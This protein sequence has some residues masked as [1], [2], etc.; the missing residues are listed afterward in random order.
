MFILCKYDRYGLISSDTNGDRAGP[1]TTGNGIILMRPF[2]EM[3][4][5]IDRLSSTNSTSIYR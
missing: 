2:E 4:E 3:A 1:I 5:W